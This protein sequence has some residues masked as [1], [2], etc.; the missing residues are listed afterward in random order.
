MCINICERFN[1]CIYN[2]FKTHGSRFISTLVWY[3]VHLNKQ[4]FKVVMMLV[5]FSSYFIRNINKN[6]SSNIFWPSRR[7]LVIW[8]STL[9][10]ILFLKNMEILE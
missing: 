9:S 3:I 2:D 8:A 10:V 4:T 1:L 7:P 5:K 6:I